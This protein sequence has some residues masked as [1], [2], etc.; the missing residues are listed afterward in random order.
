[1][2][3]VY[4]LDRQGKPLMPTKRFGHVRRMLKTGKAKAISTKPFVIQLQYESTDFIQ[5]LYGGTDPGRTNIGEAV[6]N[7][8]GE[9]VYAAHVTTRNKEIPKLMADRAT[10]RR[11]SRRGERLRRKRSPRREALRCA[12]RSAISFGISLLRVVT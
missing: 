12:A 3:V 6:L 10:Y 8:K 7:S 2:Y 5:P 1:M 4:V 9:I 11:A